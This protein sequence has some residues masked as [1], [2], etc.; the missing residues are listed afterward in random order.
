[1][2]NLLF[3]D[4]DALFMYDPNLIKNKK[5]P[6]YF[7][8]YSII[9]PYNEYYRSRIEYKD[10]LSPWKL[11]PTQFPVPQLPTTKLDFTDTV[12]ETAL[13]ISKLIDRGRTAY[14]FWSGG[15]DSTMIAVALLKNLTASQLD[16]VCFVLTSTSIEEY[17]SF[18]KKYLKDLRHVH[19]E[20]AD[21]ANFVAKLDLKNTL[22]VNG[23]GADQIIGYTPSFNLFYQNPDFVTK[24]WTNHKDFIVGNFR[25]AGMSPEHEDNIL[26]TIA[27][28]ARIAGVEIDSIYDFY[29]WINYNFKF[30]SVMFRSIPFISEKI[31]STQDFAYF[32]KNCYFNFF[33]ETKMQQWALTSDITEKLDFDRKLIKY[34]YK[35]YIYDFDNNEMYFMKKRKS[36]SWTPTK[37]TDS[38]PRHFAFDKNYQRYSIL[39][40]STR[41]QLKQLFL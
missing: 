36:H 28:T 21:M 2:N 38:I 14:L 39:D 5:Y 35:K 40:R 3:L 13:G 23:E 12:D 18:Y 27:S 10:S 16:Q 4:H 24:P 37:V 29:R 33:A 1:M 9:K 22:I 20:W 32:V 30:D 31:E 7:S 19:L 15:I 8:Y 6:E 34:A 25:K 17:P 11:E 26:D 41:Q